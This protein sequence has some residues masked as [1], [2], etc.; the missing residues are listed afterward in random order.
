M[1]SIVKFTA[2][3]V[4]Q[5][6]SK[7]ELSATPNNL[8]RIDTKTYIARRISFDVHQIE[9]RPV[10]EEE[11]YSVAEIITHSFQF[12]RGWRGWF[13][14]IFKLGIAEDLRYRLRTVATNPGRGKLQHQVCSIAIYND[15]GTNRV[16]GTVEVGIRTGTDRPQP[17]RYIYISNLAVSEQFRRRGIAVELLQD[18]ERLAQIWGHTQLFLHVMADNARALDLYQKLGY[19]VVSQEF[20][21]SWLPWW[22]C[23]ERLFMCKQLPTQVTE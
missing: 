13:I 2:D 23:P 14:P 7:S 3:R 12:D 15:R 11:I 17:Y 8:D 18:C 5:F 1:I 6:W 21:W 19:E 4:I 16:V 10:K 22:H 9:V 20:L